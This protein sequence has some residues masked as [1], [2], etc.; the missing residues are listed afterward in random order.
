MGSLKRDSV[1]EFVENWP[2]AQI[3]SPEIQV[4]VD[5]A[6]LIA[7]IEPCRTQTKVLF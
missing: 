6:A 3:L 7:R 4:H 1:R 2:G 5:F